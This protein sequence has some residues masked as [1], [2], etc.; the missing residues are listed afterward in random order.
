MKHLTMAILFLINVLGI[1]SN[2]KQQVDEEMTVHMVE[3]D[4]RVQTIGGSHVPNLQKEDLHIYENGDLQ[5][6]VYFQEISQNTMPEDKVSD[7]QQK[8]MI[9]FDFSNSDY[10][11]MRLVFGAVK[12]YF[13][14]NF[15]PNNSIGVAI[16]AGAI[17][18]LLPFSTNKEAIH[19]AIELAEMLYNPSKVSNGHI[20]DAM[21]DVKY[22][23][24]TDPDQHESNKRGVAHN[25]SINNEFISSYYSDQMNILGQFMNYLGTYSGKKNVILIT[26]P[27]G[28]AEKVKSSDDTFKH[29]WRSGIQTLQT[30]CLYEKISIHVISMTSPQYEDERQWKLDMN[31]D[32][33]DR[34]L[35]FATMTSG[36]YMSPINGRIKAPFKETIDRSGNFYRVR[37]YSQNTKKDFCEIKAN[38]DGMNRVASAQK[39]YEPRLASEE[40]F[41]DPINQNLSEPAK[42]TVNLKT[43]WM[44]W[45]DTGKGNMLGKYAVGYR[46]YGMDGRIVDEQVLMDEIITKR[47]IFPVLQFHV[48]L[49]PEQQN[50]PLKLQTIMTDLIT[51]KQVI[52]DTLNSE[53]SI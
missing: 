46:L 3:L 23:P 50:K 8:Y 37:Y 9:L 28:R 48:A 43:D 47:D 1:C 4:V 38:V 5:E 42:L 27:W 15:N 52:I 53:V 29:D 13:E 30:S 7:H 39:G 22:F 18:E 10:R 40:R 25:N 21:H 32:I 33:Q 24:T 31:F 12:T 2:I 16:Y 41:L 14:D 49:T 17:R 36:S 34:S 20:L 51:G 6:L 44:K 11:N 45:K 19:K 26:S 35:D